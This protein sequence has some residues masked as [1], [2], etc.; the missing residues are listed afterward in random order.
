M[1]EQREDPEL[2]PE[3]KQV[4][5]TTTKRDDVFRVHSEVT[6][7]TRYLLEHPSAEIVNTRTVEGAVVA[8]TAEIPRT[9][10][11]LQAKPRKSNSFAQMVSHAELQGE[12]DE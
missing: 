12:D 1:T 11:K 2:A 3:E 6:S 5:L 4:S 9:L 10:V 7:V 8:C